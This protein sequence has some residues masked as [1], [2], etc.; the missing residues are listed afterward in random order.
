[1]TEKQ[2]SSPESLPTISVL[3]LSSKGPV[4]IPEKYLCDETEARHK[5]EMKNNLS[6]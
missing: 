3:S 2:F 6:L 1:M 5:M 4:F